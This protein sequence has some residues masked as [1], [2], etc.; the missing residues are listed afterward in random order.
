MV[1]DPERNPLLLLK[2]KKEKFNCMKV[3]T[4]YKERKIECHET[5]IFLY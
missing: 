3:Y 2:G 4:I 1:A 5:A